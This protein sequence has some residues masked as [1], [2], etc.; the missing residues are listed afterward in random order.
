MW[1]YH[2]E[3]LVSSSPTFGHMDILANIGVVSLFHFKLSGLLLSLHRNLSIQE[4][5]SLQEN[6]LCKAN[7]IAY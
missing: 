4:N 7:I 6:D 3:K 1:A 2:L 5:Q